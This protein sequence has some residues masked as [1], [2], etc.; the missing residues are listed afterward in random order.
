VP[1]P[2][3]PRFLVVYS[4]PNCVSARALIPATPQALA[5]LG[6]GSKG[7]LCSLFLHFP[8]DKLTGL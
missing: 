7:R 6:A 4:N 8:L 2:G 5:R 3:R 1:F